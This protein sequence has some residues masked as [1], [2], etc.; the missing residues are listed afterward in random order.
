VV[1]TAKRLITH[2]MV[3]AMSRLLRCTTAGLSTGLAGISGC[4]NQALGGAVYPIEIFVG[5]A[6]RNHGYQ[7]VGEAA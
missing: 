3:W 1:D 7:P 6:A 4:Q 2:F 5:H